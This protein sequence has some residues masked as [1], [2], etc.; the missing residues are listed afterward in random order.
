MEKKLHIVAFDIPFP[1]NYGGIIDVFYKIKSLSEL[2]V[3]IYLHCFF[4]KKSK[5]HIELEKLCKKVMYYERNNFLFSLF[6]LLPFRVKSRSNQ[7]LLK[8]LKVVKAPILFEGLQSTYL[9]NKENL[10]K[11]FVRTHNIEHSYFFGLAKSEKN[12]F[13]KIFFFI[14]GQKL[15]NYEKVLAKTTGI[16]TISPF[17]QQYFVEK[18]GPKSTYIPVFFDATKHIFPVAETE[19]FVLYHGDLRVSD[20]IRAA[21]FLIETYK[22]SKY[23]F[24]IASSCKNKK[25]IKEIQKYPNIS[26]SD[27][28]NQNDLEVL[29]SKSHINTLITFQ[30]TGIKLKLLNALFKGNY[31]IGNSKMIEDT[32]LENH[33][34]LANT[35]EEILTKTAFLYKKDISTLDFENRFTKLST[36]QPEQSARKIIELIFKQ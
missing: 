3:E 18:Y 24:V 2:G 28:P 7:L 11:T 20:N 8:N 27:I 6:S 26:F 35:K 13:K 34:E 5:N 30:K 29:I 33:C 32:G 25:I 4:E 17:D 19:K 31:I 36:L 22:N 16:F 12:I 10:E 21:L 23:Q 9:L 14:E 1:P 15:K